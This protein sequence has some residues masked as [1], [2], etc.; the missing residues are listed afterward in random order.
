[1]SP[2]PSQLSEMPQPP[3]VGAQRASARC[4]S[5][6]ERAPTPLRRASR[7]AGAASAL[8]YGARYAVVEDR[9][10]ARFLEAARA[11]CGAD[12]WNAAADAGA[13]LS[14]EDAI[15]YALQEPRA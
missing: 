15:A 12:A 10:D 5:R 8:H 13:A 7:L 6:S 3:A 14:F 9:L 2:R 11:S 1:M 4:T